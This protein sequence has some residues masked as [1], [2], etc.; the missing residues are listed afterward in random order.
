M[1]QSLRRQILHIIVD[2][3]RGLRV[4]SGWVD[5]LWLEG[6]LDVGGEIE[7]GFRHLVEGCADVLR[8]QHGFEE[9]RVRGAVLENGVRGGQLLEDRVGGE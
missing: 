4:V 5:R 6:R 8:G 2:L 7:V 9:V 1:L 3:V